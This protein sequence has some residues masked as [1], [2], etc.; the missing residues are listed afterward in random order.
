M[1][2]VRTRIDHLHD[3]QS[4]GR[5]RRSALGGV[6]GEQLHETIKV[7]Q[8]RLRQLGRK[9][10]TNGVLRTVG[11]PSAQAD[12]AQ[13]PQ[14]RIAELLGNR[15]EKVHP[16]L[17]SAFSGAI[18]QPIGRTGCSQ[19]SFV[20]CRSLVSCR[21]R[22]SDHVRRGSAAVLGRRSRAPRPPSEEVAYA[23]SR[24]W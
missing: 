6:S 4:G 19:G 21:L 24:R 23:R 5:Y 13:L 17:Q 3:A 18:E 1:D 9:I 12:D 16:A 10:L 11:G 15:R 22:R 14:P 2:F 7:D 20:D 8:E